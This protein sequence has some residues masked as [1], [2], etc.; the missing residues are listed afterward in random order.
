MGPQT[1]E[2]GPVACASSGYSSVAAM[3]EVVQQL[4]LEAGLNRV[5]VPGSSELKQ[6]SSTPTP[7]DQSIFK[8]KPLQTPERLMLSAVKPIF[9][10]VPKAL[11]ISSHLRELN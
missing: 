10:R 8:D 2:S 4:R 5:S 1:G 6:V 11:L 9:Q 3:K 7:A